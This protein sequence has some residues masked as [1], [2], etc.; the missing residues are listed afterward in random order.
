M[1][2]LLLLLILMA[3]ANLTIAIQS[4]ARDNSVGSTN[5]EARK[6]D[7]ENREEWKRLHPPP[8][9]LEK[10]RFGIVAAIFVGGMILVLL[11]G[12]P[13]KP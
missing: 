6:R 8:P 5:R 11:V 10:L 4:A 3:I 7:R 9:W 1:T 12:P 13:V 2:D